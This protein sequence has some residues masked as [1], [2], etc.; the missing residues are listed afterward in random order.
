MKR[1]STS[2]IIREMQIKTTSSKSLSPFFIVSNE[3]Y[4]VIHSTGSRKLNK[5]MQITLRL[6]PYVLAL[7]CG[8][9][10][11]TA[12]ANGSQGPDIDPGTERIGNN[13]I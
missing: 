8:V 13:V 12:K 2:L 3:D 5:L 1:C 10:L 7:F 4:N 6:K 11:T 9:G